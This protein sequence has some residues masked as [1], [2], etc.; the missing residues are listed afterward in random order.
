MIFSPLILQQNHISFSLLVMG[1]IF[2]DLSGP[3]ATHVGV[4]SSEVKNEFMPCSSA[5]F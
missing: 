2:D 4:L 5:Y 3:I 1:L